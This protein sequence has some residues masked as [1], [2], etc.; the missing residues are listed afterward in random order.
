MKHTIKMTNQ[1]SAV[2]VLFL[3]LMLMPACTL[4]KHT[5][6]PGAAV[7]ADKGLAAEAVKTASKSNVKASDISAESEWHVAKTPVNN[8]VDASVFPAFNLKGAFK[9]VGNPQTNQ[10]TEILTPLSDIL[11]NEKYVGDPSYMTIRLQQM[12]QVFHQALLHQLDQGDKSEKFLE[13]KKK[14]FETVFAGCS[15]DL[16]SDC[17]NAAFFSTDTRLSRV[18]TAYARDLDVNID[19]QIAE[20]KT[21][22]ACVQNSETCRNLLETRYRILAMALFRK[23]NRNDD[24]TFTFAYL[25]YARP[26]ALL[27]DYE[28]KENAKLAAAGQEQP[29]D[30]SLSYLNETHG[31]I[32]ETLIAKYTPSD[33][34]NKEFRAFVENFNPW[35]YSKKK[36]DLFQYGTRTMFELGAK[37][38]LYVDQSKTTL[39]PAVKNAMKESQLTPDEFGPTIS[40]MVQEIRQLYGD[41]IFKNMGIQD[42]AA[43]AANTDS[44]FYNEFFFIVD[45]LFREN[46]STAEVEMVLQNANSARVATE[47]PKMIS[48]YI[49]INLLYMVVYTN[50]FMKTKIYDANISSNEVFSVAVTRSRELT[51][52]WHKVQAQ[53]DLLDGLMGSYFKTRGI[54]TDEYVSTVKLISSVDRNIHYLSVYPNMVVMNYFLAKMDGVITVNTWW[55]KI[56]IQ[57]ASVIQ[58]FFDGNVNDPWFRFGKD[59]EP[60]S[61]EMLLY[62]MEYLLSTETLNTFVAKDQAGNGGNDRSKFL[63]L[64]FSKYLQNDVRDIGTKVLDYERKTVSD[65]SFESVNGICDYETNAKQQGLAPRIELSLMDLSRFTYTGLGDNGANALLGKFLVE[66]SDSVQQL[67]TDTESRITYVKAIVDIIEADLIRSGK[68]QKAGDPHPD[69]AQARNLIQ[70]LEALKI[71][72]SKLFLQNHKNYFNCETTLQEIERRRANRLYEEERAHLGRIY[73]MMAPLAALQDTASLNAEVKKVNDDYFRNPQNG[74]RFDRFNGL[75]YVMSKYDLLMRM[76]KRVESDI[77]TQTTTR[78]QQVYGETLQKYNKVRSVNVSIPAGLERDDMVAQGT[79]IA[80]YY[81]GTKQDFIKQGMKALSGSGDSFVQWQGQMSSD[82]KL[83]SYIA[84]LDE[85]YLLGPVNDGSNVYQVTKEELAQA[86]VSMMAS[87]TMDDFD[88]SNA[89]DFNID[90]RFP[91]S[92]YENVLFQ[93][94]GQTRLPFFR[95]LMA[96]LYDYGAIRI[97][98]AG[99][100]N[101][102]MNFASTINNLGTFVFEPS[103]Q[104]AKSVQTLYG[105]RARA[106]YKRVNDLYVYVQKLEASISDVTSLDS[107]LD[108][109]FYMTSGVPT[110][111]RQD[112]VKNL[113]DN[114]KMDDLKISLKIFGQKTNGFYKANE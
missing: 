48:A 97:G 98:D 36:T 96:G 68:I 109:P 34:N 35:V 114:R 100:I 110:K 49:K 65:P 81:H 95:G 87:Y 30:L 45:R 76:K 70:Q 90:G 69:T 101:E 61:R 21:S 60:L 67:R 64:I 19:A 16:K 50:Q 75:S 79:S 7:G 94:D 5:P 13:I 73:D 112:G 88:I 62:S 38:C 113:F 28:K 107:R 102:A 47:L 71:R 17:K 10:V 39:S 32:F 4:S 52:R 93:K 12:L 92:F 104:V 63:D 9:N 44:A 25:K 53:I 40:Q 82:K 54:E 106:R 103:Q 26:F 29:G 77:F 8:A 43:Q 37:C 66:V 6:P 91:R 24:Q 42:L 111:W 3:T 20:N 22:E 11:L 14:Y 18:M 58:S 85:F 105:Q 33:L 57:A 86:Y 55:G 41:E 56:E 80:L 23:S 108:R 59:V 15:R 89:Q 99:P 51:A 46:L 84:N 78:E 74:Y 83:R 31:K 2:S 1:M 27:M 72:V